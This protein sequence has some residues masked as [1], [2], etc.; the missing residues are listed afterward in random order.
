MFALVQN[1]CDSHTDA[2]TG[3]PDFAEPYNQE[4]LLAMEAANTAAQ[5]SLSKSQGATMGK[6]NKRSA[7]Y[8]E[9]RTLSGGLQKTTG[10][11]GTFFIDDMNAGEYTMTME[12]AG[13]ATKTVQ[14]NIVDGEGTTI[15]ATPAP[16]N[17]NGAVVTPANPGGGTV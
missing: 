14:V 9:T 15:Q 6:K 5:L 16:T 10:A 12:R 4:F 2:W 13:Y 1:V 8:D 3:F 17:A 7:M 11:Q